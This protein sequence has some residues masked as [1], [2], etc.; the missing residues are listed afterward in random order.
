MRLYG[1]GHSPEPGLD[2]LSEIDRV[3]VRVLDV[4]HAL[5]PR[6]VVRRAEHPAAQDLDV[7]EQA[8]HV[9][10]LPVVPLFEVIPV[11]EVFLLEVEAEE[12]TVPGVR[13]R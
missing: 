9:P 8:R 2:G 7:V 3:P 13:P 1:K 5:S 6:H 12:V 4:R 11:I 10:D